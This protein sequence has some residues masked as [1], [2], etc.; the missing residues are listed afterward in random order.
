MHEERKV[1]FDFLLAEC[2]GQGMS[3]H[4]PPSLGL[5]NEALTLWSSWGNSQIPTMV[6]VESLPCLALVRIGLALAATI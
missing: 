5:G 1:R 4:A 2:V 3:R 6:F